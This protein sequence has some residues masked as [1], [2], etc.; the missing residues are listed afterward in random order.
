[1][2]NSTSVLDITSKLT[3]DRDTELIKTSEVLVR[4][5]AVGIATSTGILENA[6][7]THG[8]LNVGHQLNGKTSGSGAAVTG[9]G[10]EEAT[11][12][13]GGYIA[14]VSVT[15]ASARSDKLKKVYAEDNQ[16]YTLTANVDNQAIGFVSQSRSN[17]PAC[18]TIHHEQ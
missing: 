7:D 14:T 6:D 3:A 16:T 5:G 11:Y 10:T 8:L 15:G 17:L 13:P 4:G 9:D 12:Q 18:S 1:M 2:A